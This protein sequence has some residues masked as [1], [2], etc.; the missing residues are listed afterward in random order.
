MVDCVSPCQAVIKRHQTLL[1]IKEDILKN[2]STTMNQACNSTNHLHA[3]MLHNPC[4]LM[5]S[6]EKMSS[7]ITNI[8][9]RCRSEICILVA[10]NLCSIYAIQHL[11]AKASQLE[12]KLEY[13][14]N[15]NSKL[16]DTV[17]RN[18]Q[19]YNSKVVH[20]ASNTILSLTF[21]IDMSDSDCTPSYWQHG[22]NV[23][24]A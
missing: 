7:F 1:S 14:T 8:Q 2:I 5:N 12:R 10:L 22:T 15:R 19:M 24:W 23:L 17:L 21:F 16:E 4:S 9:K 20:E 3:C 11:T 18:K 6:K 13:L